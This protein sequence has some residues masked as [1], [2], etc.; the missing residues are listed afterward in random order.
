ME[1]GDWRAPNATVDILTGLSAMNSGPRARGSKVIGCPGS[2]RSDPTA[3]QELRPEPWLDPGRPRRRSSVAR[4]HPHEG[5]GRNAGTSA[6]HG[7]AVRHSSLHAS[8]WERA[9]LAG[10]MGIQGSGRAGASTDARSAICLPAVKSGPRSIAISPIRRRASCPRTRGSGSG[11][12]GPLYSRPNSGTSRPRSI[13]RQH[14]ACAARPQRLDA[15]ARDVGD[16]TRLLAPFESR[17][18]ASH[19]VTSHVPRAASRLPQANLGA[20]GDRRGREQLQGFD[21][22]DA[23][24]PRFPGR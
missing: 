2:R 18:V 20:D 3:T 22:L 19:T 13:H 8:A 6:A 16:A 1:I 17:T 9:R 5:T 23:L 12:S 24:W 14:Q 15:V 4:W 10:R 7:R 11:W 21:R